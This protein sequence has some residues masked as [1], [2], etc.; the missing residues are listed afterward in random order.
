MSIRRPDL[1]PAGHGEL[2]EPITPEGLGP[3]DRGALRPVA[4]PQEPGPPKRQPTAGGVKQP[5][6]TEKERSK[7]ERD[8]DEHVIGDPAREDD[9]WE[10][11]DETFDKR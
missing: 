3:A 7:A 4:K 10:E 5:L 9:R 11:P 2:D 8:P 1:G 6:G